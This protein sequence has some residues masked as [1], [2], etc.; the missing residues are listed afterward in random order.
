MTFDLFSTPEMRSDAYYDRL[1]HHIKSSAEHLRLQPEKARLLSGELADIWSGA[2]GTYCLHKTQAPAR[3][4]RLRSSA[5]TV[6][7]LCVL[8]SQFMHSE[9][10]NLE[11]ISTKFLVSLSIVLEQLRGIADKCN[12]TE[13]NF[14]LYRPS[15]SSDFVV[16]LHTGSRRTSGGKPVGYMFDYT[17]YFS[18]ALVH[19]ENNKLSARTC[20]ENITK[21]NTA[22]HHT[23][24]VLQNTPHF[25]GVQQSE[26]VK[27]T[28][29]EN[30]RI[31]LGIYFEVLDGVET[32][33]QGC[34]GN[35]EPALAAVQ[36]ACAQLSS[37]YSDFTLSAIKEEL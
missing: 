13:G 33:V 3:I 28:Y 23:V 22:L 6:P 36:K 32:F 30:S 18:S 9:D 21:L 4:E 12:F 25:I 19:E 5:V 2:Y 8:L 35:Y 20:V 27:N 1:K 29:L 26:G 15:D 31:A 37:K 7:S 24:A 10:L 34:K 17:G 14:G 16:Q 11:N